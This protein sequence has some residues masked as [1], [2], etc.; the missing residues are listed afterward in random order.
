MRKVKEAERERDRNQVKKRVNWLAFIQRQAPQH[1]VEI[2]SPVDIR[3]PFPSLSFT[4]RE[5]RPNYLLWQRAV[6]PLPEGTSGFLSNWKSKGSSHVAIV[7]STTTII[8]TEML[9]KGELNVSTFTKLKWP[10]YL[11]FHQKKK[12]NIT[13]FFIPNEY[14]LFLPNISPN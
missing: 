7:A 12:T 14:L 5:T 2:C 6:V 9:G 3:F 8:Q 11:K 13:A 1:H 4:C 10:S